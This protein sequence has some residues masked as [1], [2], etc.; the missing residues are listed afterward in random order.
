V[1]SANRNFAYNAT[2]AA[3]ILYT[4]TTKPRCDWDP[5]TNRINV[6]DA[7][8]GTSLVENGSYSNFDVQT[9]PISSPGISI[10]DNASYTPMVCYANGFGIATATGKVTST[11]SDPADGL[12]QYAVN[13][14]PLNGSWLVA[15]TASGSSQGVFPQ[16]NGSKTDPNDWRS[17]IYSTAFGEDP[18]IRVRY[19]KTGTTICSSGNRLVTPSDSTRSW[20]LS[21]TGID[22]LVDVESGQNTTACV[23]SKFIDFKLTGSGLSSGSGTQLWQV[24]EGSNWVSNTG[25]GPLDKPGE[26]ARVP[27]NALN[28]TKLQVKFQGRDSNVSPHVS[29]LTGAV[30]L[31]FTCH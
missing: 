26:F 14:T 22:T 2:N 7:N 3:F 30:T 1:A 24:G 19:C 29:G 16:F 8:G 20:Q 23:R 27:R 28:V 5:N 31:E 12:F 15:L 4:G 10:Q 9:E 11:L 18:Q 21:I 17:N 25:S 13:Q 6:V